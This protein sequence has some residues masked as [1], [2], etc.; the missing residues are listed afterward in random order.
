VYLT[1]G[2]GTIAYVLLGLAGVALLVMLTR[3]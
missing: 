2:M 1:Q 3:R